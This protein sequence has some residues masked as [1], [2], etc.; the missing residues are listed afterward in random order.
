[1]ATSGPSLD[2]PRFDWM[3]ATIRD[4]VDLIANTLADT[5]GGVVETGRGLNGYRASRVVKRD[6]E[7]LARVLFG[8]NGNPHL[9]ATGAA[10]DDVVP[11]LRGEWPTEHEVTRMDSAQDFDDATGFERLR[12][13]M[14]SVSE[15]PN[16]SVT[17]IESRKAG[18]R[19]R[20]VYLGSPSSRVRARLYEKGRFEHQQGNTDA[21]V[22]WLRL[23]V[24][25]RPKGR[26]ARTLASSLDPQEAWGVSSWTRDLARDA[27][28]VEVE[29]VAMQPK[30]EPDY[31][32]AIA[33]CRRQYADSLR[34]ALAVEGSWEKV[35]QLLG[36]LP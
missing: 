28:G 9:I 22:N 36:V 14:V 20:T 17:E 24:Q 19:S 12:R 33:A 34:R 35:G 30:R 29:R 26:D 32:R 18:V 27:M 1:M 6:E 31:A 15:G 23:E 21:P 2:S 8:G 10:S 4:D 11:V 25:V 5:L 16:L 7:T 13:V 3:Q